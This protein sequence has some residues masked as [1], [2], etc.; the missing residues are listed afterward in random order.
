M[1]NIEIFFFGTPEFKL[2]IQIL[3]TIKVHELIKQIIEEYLKDPKCD[4]SRLLYPHFPQAYEL[5]IIDDDRDYYIPDMG[6]PALDPTRD[7]R[8]IEFDQIAFIQNP[9]FHPP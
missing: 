1:R 7:I 6:I 5:R 4:N 3:K 2:N 9:T 8:T